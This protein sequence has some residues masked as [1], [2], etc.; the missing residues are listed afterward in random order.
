MAALRICRRV[1]YDNPAKRSLKLLRIGG[2][3]R[4]QIKII[5]ADNRGARPIS[6]DCKLRGYVWHTP[7]F[8]NGELSI[9]SRKLAYANTIFFAYLERR[10]LYII[11]N[12]HTLYFE[13]TSYRPGM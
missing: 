5:E 11:C 13:Y 4:R 2:N 7:E 6:R 10:C 1:K 3:A 12:P 9:P 8:N